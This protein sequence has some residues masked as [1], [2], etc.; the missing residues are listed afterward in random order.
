MGKLETSPH[1][2][3]ARRCR[4]LYIPY[5]RCKGLMQLLQ[6]FHHLCEL[7]GQIDLEGTPEASLGLV[8]WMEAHAHAK[9]SKRVVRAHLSR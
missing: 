9:E 6:T 2:Q 3:S 7:S 5:L 4:S 1:R 8:K